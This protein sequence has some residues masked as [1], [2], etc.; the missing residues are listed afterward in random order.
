MSQTPQIPAGPIARGERI[1]AL[2]LLRG[3]AVLGILLANITAFAHPDLAYY[4][5]GALP[6]GGNE[7]DRVMWVAQ[8]VLVDG[9][10]RGLFAILFGA[11]MV[12][13]VERAGV[14]EK[15]VLLQARRLAWL[16]L[17][18]LLHLFLLF[19]GDILF[20]YAGAG[21]VALFALP[22]RGRMQLTIGVGWAA[23][24]ALMLLM[25]YEPGLRIEQGWGTL[26]EGAA[27]LYRDFWSERMATARADA[28]LM[29]NGSYPAIVRAALVEEG[30]GLAGVFGANF[31]E[32]IPTMLIGMGLYRLG[33]FTRGGGAGRPRWFGAALLAFVA[34][35]AI[36]LAAG[37]FAYEE[38]FAPYT[39]Q[40]VFFGV[41]PL[42]DVLQVTGG[43][44]L[45]G[46]WASRPHDGWLTDRL[47]LAGRMAFTNY[48]GTSLVM[49]LA[50]QGWAG[51]LFGT[52]H[53]L[54]LL[55][56]V[57]LGWALM[58]T[59]SRIWLKHFRYGPLEWLWRCLTY[60]RLF[61]LRRP[62]NENAS[63]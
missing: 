43:A 19:R 41:T 11:G 55:P 37:L 63:Q 46:W 18:G 7:S 14:F 48:V 34:G 49:M 21:L 28:A 47:A 27:Q 2:D 62:G 23:V 42:A 5:P 35:A 24:G 10:F 39:T 6:G 1:V 56:A 26:P 31:Y 12:L 33:V 61:P 15:A 50:F 38:G 20:A 3:I 36:N 44:A 53:R 4:W 54:E 25:T 59:F 22:L 45:L 9:K 17:F 40:F 57:A 16:A 51:G 60:W 52:L 32:T 29:T 8:L 30:P 13:F 58:L